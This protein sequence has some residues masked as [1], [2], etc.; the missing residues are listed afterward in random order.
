M[1]DNPPLTD[2]QVYELL[3]EIRLKL[4]R[5]TVSTKLGQS[6][7]ATALRDIDALQMAMVMIR[8]EATDTPS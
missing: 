5:R 2:D 8:D 4:E 7:I 1:T 3:Q 6:V